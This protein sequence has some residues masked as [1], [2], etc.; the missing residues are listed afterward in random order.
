MSTGLSI[1]TNTLANAASENLARNQAA[2]ETS[3]TRL[4]SGLRINSAADDPSGLAI[5]QSLQSQVAGF[6]QAT[7]NVQNATSA[8]SIADGALAATTAL[9]QRIRTLAVEASS[10]SASSADKANLQAE[11]SEL[12]LEVNRVAENT[13]FNGVSLLDGSH[14]GFQP[15]QNAYLRITSNSVLAS[16]TATAPAPSGPVTVTA[17]DYV[18]PLPGVA[19]TGTLS[20]LVAGTT[21]TFSGTIDPGTWFWALSLDG[22]FVTTGVLGGPVSASFVATGPTETFSFGVFGTGTFTVSGVTATPAG[23]GPPVTAAPVTSAAGLLVVSAVAANANFN[24]TATGAQGF[25]AGATGTLDGTIEVQVINTGTSIAALETFFSSAA[26]TNPASVSPVLQAPDTISTLF[27]NVSITFGNFSTADVGTTAYIKV[28]QNVAAASNPNAA[29]LTIQS[30]ANEG[31]TLQVGF[32]GVSTQA[33]RIS[34]INLLLSSSASPSLGAEDAIGQI[35]NALQYLLNTR[36][37][38]GSAIVRLGEDAQND[39]GAAVNLQASASS[40][41]DLNVGSETTNFNKLQLL[42][43]IGTLVLTDAEDNAT[44]VLRLFR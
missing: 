40:I 35:D 4:S 15:E 6:D 3:V 39:T 20:G 17:P 37:T 34:N 25:T 27:D 44:S 19:P 28:S 38:I 21:Y 42:G 16:A 7:Q 33:L 2:L 10:D 13:T 41:G 30:G 8:A 24:T 11:V 29:A 1:A 43:S 14:A 31:A 32:A 22:S 12:L 18:Y 36:A 23:G 5:S 9:L 26:T